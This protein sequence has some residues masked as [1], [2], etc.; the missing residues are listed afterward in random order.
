MVALASHAS[1]QTLSDSDREALLERLENLSATASE[2][3]DARFRSAMSAFTSAMNS[4][5]AA[6]ELYMKCV[7]KVDFEDQKKKN[8]DFREWRRKEDEKLSKPGFKLALRHQLRW[9]V[10]TLHAASEKADRTRL[11]GEAQQIV[12]TIFRDAEQLAGQQQVLKQSVT[13]SVFA[14]AY[15]INSVK[16]DKWP[17]SPIQLQQVYNDVLLPPY[18]TPGTTSQLRAAWIKRIQQEGMTHEHWSPSSRANKGAG[19]GKETKARI[20]M[21]DDMRPPEYDKFMADTLPKLQWEMEVDLF[22]NGDQTGAAARM[23]GH[24]EKYIAHPSATEWSKQF[25]ELLE[26]PK[27]EKKPV[28]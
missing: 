21:A 11:A 25:R 20:G 8:V 27:E 6:Y 1:S 23:L 26:G 19:D 18:R 10:L 14:R 24:L 15:E 12:D 9:L 3:V 7:E 16:V 22:K 13:D 4:E 2:R 17:M 28:S 5:D